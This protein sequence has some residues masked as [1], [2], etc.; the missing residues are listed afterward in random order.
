MRRRKEVGLENAVMYNK[1]NL[2]SMALMLKGTTDPEIV[3]SVEKAFKEA[4]EVAGKSCEHLD[5]FRTRLNMDSEAESFP[6]GRQASGKEARDIQARGQGRDEPSEPQ[7][8]PEARKTPTRDQADKGRPGPGGRDSFFRSG[9]AVR[10][11]DRGQA[12]RA[13]MVKRR[14][15]HTIAWPPERLGANE[16]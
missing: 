1:N 10:D 13:R 12:L 11:E 3:S 16:S 4:I 7:H 9:R 14:H 2:A 8:D 15:Q 5:S 6:R